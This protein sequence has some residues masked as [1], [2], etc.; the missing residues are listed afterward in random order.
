MYNKK[1]YQKKWDAEHKEYKK[2]KARE[3]KSKNKEYLKAYKK[4]YYKE[5]KESEKEY[6]RKRNKQRRNKLL[7]IISNG[8]PVCVRCGCNDTRLLEINHINGG[9]TKEV[10]GKVVTFWNN[11]IKGTRATDDLELLCKV[12][13]AWHALELKFGKLPFTITYEK[14]I[15]NKA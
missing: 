14:I 10:R 4:K 11:I 8:N 12:C 7:D 9:G 6:S 5:H 2:I 1:E 13:N 15:E 3:W